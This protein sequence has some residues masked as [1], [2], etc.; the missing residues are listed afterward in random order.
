ML[1][2]VLETVCR[3]HWRITR[4]RRQPLHVN[5]QTAQRDIYVCSTIEI[6]L[7]ILGSGYHARIC[8]AIVIHHDGN[9]VTVHFTWF[10]Q[11]LHTYA[12]HLRTC[13]RNHCPNVQ[14]GVL[15]LLPSV[16]GVR[17]VSAAL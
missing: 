6:E 11:R 16:W 15:A 10:W 7:P 3:A 5:L 4:E 17:T 14:D 13:C 1:L 12:R 2:A 9:A 8:S